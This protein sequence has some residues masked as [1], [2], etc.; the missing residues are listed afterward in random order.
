MLHALDALACAFK[1]FSDCLHSTTEKTEVTHLIQGHKASV[2]E[3]QELG[4]APSDSGCWLLMASRKD[5]KGKNRKE[6]GKQK[7]S[8]ACLLESSGK[9]TP[10][11]ILISWI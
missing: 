11:E 10:L 1:Q 5:H 4:A 7:V 9:L 3:S 8:L 2:W 6:G